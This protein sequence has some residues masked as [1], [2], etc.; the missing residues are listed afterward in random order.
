MLL[1]PA[2]PQSERAD[3]PVSVRHVAL[4][5]ALTES[6]ASMI[7][8]GHHRPAQGGRRHCVDDQRS[9][10]RKAFAEADE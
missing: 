5:S 6:P 8:C 2:G 9:S 3:H 10:D 1:K 4:E 7:T